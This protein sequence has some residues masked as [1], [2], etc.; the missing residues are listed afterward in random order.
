MFNKIQNDM[1][2]AMKNR[3]KIKRES[4]GNLIGAIKNAGIAI[5]IKENFSDELVLK[6]LQKETRIVQEQIDTCPDSAL[7]KKELF[8]MRLNLYKQ[9]LPKMMTKE[10]IIDLLRK[11]NSYD[12]VV[13]SA[14]KNLMGGLMTLAKSLVGNSAEGKDIS[15]AVKFIIKERE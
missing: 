11:K 15:D 14:S 7:D 12:I 4:L 6:V 5:G 13:S 10:E 8:N 1:V 2:S 3:D 9:Y